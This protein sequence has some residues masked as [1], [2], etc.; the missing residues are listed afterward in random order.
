MREALL[1]YLHLMRERALADYRVA[2]L[3][4]AIIA[5]HVARGG[6]KLK[7]PAVPRILRPHKGEDDGQ[8]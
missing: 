6:K 3:E 8:E 4:F 5:P 7:P 1:A 2:R